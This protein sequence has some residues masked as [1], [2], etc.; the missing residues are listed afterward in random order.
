MGTDVSAQPIRF[1]PGQS[2]HLL[3]THDVYIHDYYLYTVKTRLTNQSECCCPSCL[4]VVVWQVFVMS[5]DWQMI[6]LPVVWQV[7][8]MS[9]NRQVIVLPVVW[10]VLVMSDDRQVI[11]LPVVWQVLLTSVS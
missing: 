11:V 2:T 10:Q 8:V 3:H 9:D 1:V 7:L 4:S 5:D 6:V